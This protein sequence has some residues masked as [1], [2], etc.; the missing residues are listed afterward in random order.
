MSTFRVHFLTEL[1]WP[2]TDIICDDI[3]LRG[4]AF[5]GL[6]NSVIVA[7]WAEDAV[8]FIERLDPKPNVPALNIYRLRWR[9]D[10]RGEEMFAAHA[11]DLSAD[12]DWIGASDDI[13][14]RL[15]WL[16]LSNVGS[17]VLL[18]SRL[19]APPT[20]TLGQTPAL[21]AAAVESLPQ[22]EA[23]TEEPPAEETP[24]PAEEETSDNP[25]L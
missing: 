12:S 15:G 7:I 16:R 24:A 8:S 13:G 3:A 22:P 17:A 20:V 10:I 18:M 19:T 4:G 14:A 5:V 6:S 9:T 2:D 21:P 11:I 1:Q 25:T 23:P